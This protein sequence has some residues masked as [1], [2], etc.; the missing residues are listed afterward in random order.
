MK[1]KVV[2]DKR[3][4]ERLLVWRLPNGLRLGLVPRRGW[5]EKFG[6]VAVR[7]G[8]IDTRFRFGDRLV[9]L[10]AGTAHLLEHL[11]FEQPDNPLSRILAALSIDS[12]AMTTHTSTAVE[13]TTSGDILQ[14]LEPL[15]RT[16]HALRIDSQRFQNEKS[17]VLSELH[18]SAENPDWLMTNTL[19][20]ALYRSHPV[21]YDIVGTPSSIRRIRVEHLETAFSAF[22]H[23]R[24]AVISFSGDI[25]EDDFAAAVEK[26][27]RGWHTP[28]RIGE[29]L[30]KPEGT[31]PQ[32]GPIRLTAPMQRQKF[33]IAYKDL[34]P[35]T[36]RP[37]IR[38]LLAAE[39]ALTCLIGPSSQNYQRLYERG[40]ID[41]SF[42][43]GYMADESF[44]HAVLG[45]DSDDAEASAAEVM[46]TLE[47][48]ARM[49]ISEED[50]RRL[51]NRAI[52]V[53]I[54]R[55]DS[56]SFVASA[57]AAGL[58]YGFFYT[59]TLH[60]LETISRTEVERLAR[61]LF[62]PSKRSVVYLLPSR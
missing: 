62:V 28:S 57:L 26:A 52:G 54:R 15:A 40:V 44:A 36:H 33:A 9:R 16:L 11:L 21:R 12:N 35:R 27:F 38:R 4:G 2:E 37:L 55:L 61:Q 1:A 42:G 24:N 32:H 3:F 23:P 49:G 25:D 20:K 58:F 18:M 47:E 39:I 17:V 34:P 29:P 46:E 19:M 22:Y 53:Y 31:P 51:R 56:P 30:R 43:A 59:E 6:L 10:P 41:D 45:G 7:F 14:S 8:S 60:F 5:T 48:S 13:V 50:F